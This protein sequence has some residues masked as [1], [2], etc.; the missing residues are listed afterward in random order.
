MKIAKKTGKL[1]LKLR[2]FLEG[3]SEV[4][5]SE[6]AKTLRFYQFKASTAQ[7]F[8][9]SL[10][11]TSVTV[12]DTPHYRL[13]SAL[14]QNTGVVE[15]EGYY[16]A[17]LAASWGAA[18]AN[19]IPSRIDA[20][21]RHFRAFQGGASAQRA[22]LTYLHPDFAPFVVDGNHR[23]AFAA[24]L[25]KRS[26]VEVLPTDLALILFSK[27]NEFYGTGNRGMP[28]QSVFLNGTEVVKGRR[29][30]AIERLSMIPSP[31]IKGK[32]IL[33]VASNIGMSALNAKRLGAAEC[34]GLEISPN[35]VDLASRFSMFEGAFPDVRF[36]QFNVDE[37]SLPT[38]ERYD[39]AFMFSIH[40]HLKKPDNLAGIA[41]D[42]VT[43]YVVFEGHPGATKQNY[44]KFFE[45]GQF[46]NISDIGSLSE[47]RFNQKPTRPLW[48]CEK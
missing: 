26:R 4:L 7:F 47:S 41:R 9:D 28:Y 11:K 43:K 29:N 17:Y 33:D 6:R 25:G 45:S 10:G 13:A 3:R 31:V 14:A 34:I 27:A 32:R 12:E 46:K 37:D 36:R 16:A 15:A 40:D 23:F 44:T 5:D 24:A 21:K 18:R 8:F 19:D 1:K 22:I 2:R 38:G 20:F 42:H 48:L 39:T 30:D 35:M